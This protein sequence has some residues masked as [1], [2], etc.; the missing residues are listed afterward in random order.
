MKQIKSHAKNG[1]A[2]VFQFDVQST[3]LLPRMQTAKSYYKSK[4]NYHNM[5][6]YNVANQE[7][8]NYWFCEVDASLEASTYASIIIDFLEKNVTERKSVYLISDGCAAQ[9]RN[10]V[11]ASALLRLA[12]KKKVLYI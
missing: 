2:Y 8:Q 5:T 11:L 10:A 4:I 6:F 7:A 3:K 12:V 9:N 1:T